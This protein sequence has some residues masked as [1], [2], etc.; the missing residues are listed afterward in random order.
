M[1]FPEEENGLPFCIFKINA[2]KRYMKTT[3]K[4]VVL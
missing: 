3:K 4:V 2:T 1:T